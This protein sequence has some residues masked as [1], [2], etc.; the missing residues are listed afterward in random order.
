MKYD[1]K[2]W[3][4]FARYQIRR[5]WR[6]LRCGFWRVELPYCQQIKVPVFKIVDN[7]IIR[8]S[9]IKAR[10]F[11]I[12]DRAQIRAKNQCFKGESGRPSIFHQLPYERYEIEERNRNDREFFGNINAALA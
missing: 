11:Y 2:I 4:A 7:P 5:F 3:S 9:E 8:I 1:L 6:R 12:V 10:R